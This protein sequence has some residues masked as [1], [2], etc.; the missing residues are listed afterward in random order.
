MKKSDSFSVFRKQSVGVIAIAV[1]KYFE[2]VIRQAIWPLIIV[3]FFGS[4]TDTFTRIIIYVTVVAGLFSIVASVLRYTHYYFCVKGGQLMV[5]KGVLT[6]KNISVPF[7]KIQKVEFEQNIVHRI[8]GVTTLRVET[9]GAEEEE[10]EIGALKLDEAE[11]LR[12]ILLAGKRTRGEDEMLGDEERK[13]QEKEVFSL[14]L[15]DLIRAGL[16]RNHLQTLG[17]VFGFI[18]GVYFQFQDVLNLDER[19]AEQLPGWYYASDQWKA[20]FL[21][22]P[23]LLLVVIGISLIRTVFQYF[24]FKMWR[25]SEGYQVAYGAF[26]RRTYSSLDKK[27]QYVFWRDNLLMRL[28]RMFSLAIYQA[29]SVRMGRSQAIRVP[30]CYDEQIEMILH[31][32]YRPYEDPNVSFYRT[33]FAYFMLLLSRFAFIP[34]AIFTLVSWLN[35]ILLPSFLWSGIWL[36]MVA[37]WSYHFQNNLLLAIN[38]RF[39]VIKKGVF[40]HRKWVV[41]YNKLQGVSL[42]SNPFE[43]RRNLQSIRLHSAAGDITFPYLEKNA[44][45]RLADVVLYRIEKE[46]VEWM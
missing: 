14:S 29:G 9:A 36:L 7:E 30:F 10:V 42:V 41:Q 2:N 43:E 4:G 24:G 3:Y 16:L 40:S 39:I 28:V 46:K 37:L 18:A 31:D 12:E 25:K 34:I 21:L 23:L 44:A 27:V 15:F 1:V 26:N 35:G 32:I 20:V 33:H 13:E 11:E 45:H 22:I 19:L 5:K 17:L 8:L 6:T 38:E